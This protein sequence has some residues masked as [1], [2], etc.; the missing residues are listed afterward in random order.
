MPVRVCVIP[1]PLLQV[2]GQPRRAPPD[3][4]PRPDSDTITRPR[5][6]ERHRRTR[7]VVPSTRSLTGAGAEADTVTRRCMARRVCANAHGPRVPLDSRRCVNVT[8]DLITMKWVHVK[9]PLFFSNLH[10]FL[11]TVRFFFS[12]LRTLCS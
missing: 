5:T 12:S 11:F 2:P 9:I 10:S 8:I 1:K 4:R 3:R 6:T 7:V